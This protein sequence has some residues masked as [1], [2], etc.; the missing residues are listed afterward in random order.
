LA[1]LN[2]RNGFKFKINIRQDLQ[3]HLDE[4]AF[5]LEYLVSGKRNPINPV[6]LAAAAGPNP[7]PLNPEPPNG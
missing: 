1:F 4:R 5:G 2:P 7:E 3:D 6:K